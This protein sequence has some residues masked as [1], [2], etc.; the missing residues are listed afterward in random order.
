MRSILVV[1]SDAEQTDKVKA[2]LGAEGVWIAEVGD[3]TQALRVAADQ[4]PD[5]VVV[6]S[7]V[8]GSAELVRS[9]GSAVG[10][11]GSVLLR[12]KAGDAGAGEADSVLDLPL[13]SGR[14]AEEV[15]RLLAR[16]RAASASAPQEPGERR[17]TAEEIFG[18]ILREVEGTDPGWPPLLEPEPA[19]ALGASGAGGETAP[20]SAP[21]QAAESPAAAGE[22]AEQPPELERSA[23]PP[24]AATEPPSRPAAETPA[25]PAAPAAASHRFGHYEL[26]ER[27]AVGGMA[28]IW[29]ARMTSVEGFEK[30]V[31]IKKI[32]P[33]LSDSGDFER[34]FVE[35]A[36]L[37]AGLNHEN[38][39][40]IY[41]LGKVNEQYF[42]AMEYVEGRDLGAILAAARRR[43]ER[44]PTGLAV[45]VGARLAA[46]LDYAHRRPDAG[47]E[48]NAVVHRDVS[49][50]NVLVGR[51]G[52]IKLCD[53]GVAK[54]ASSVAS[55]Q[56]GAIKGKIPYMSPE[57]AHGRAVDGRSDLFSLGAVLFEMATGR[58]LFSADSEIS[59]L[60][61][62]RECRV[63]DPRELE[64]GLPDAFAEV[65]L[66]AL[67]R[68][69]DERFASASEMQHQLEQILYGLRPTPGAE[70]LARYLEA[71]FSPAE[72]AS[73]PAPA[74]RLAIQPLTPPPAVGP[75]EEREDE[76]AEETGGG[77]F[78]PAAASPGRNWLRLGL[79]ALLV[80][81][82]AAL[83]FFWLDGSGTEPEA[84]P[85]APVVA[86]PEPTPVDPAEPV[87][88][89]PET[90][91][92]PEDPAPAAGI[93][94]LVSRE[95]ARERAEREAELR[96]LF[97]EDEATLQQQLDEL[98]ESQ[99]GP[100]PEGGGGSGSGSPP[101]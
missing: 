35:E 29:T 25:V 59:L 36:K 50:R 5:L 30:R 96:R 44:V 71:V 18:D 17:L 32:L 54:M 24:E 2:A 39:I 45:L 97:Q 10:G 77:V 56:I 83:A 88:D 99:E 9:F 37:A 65:I 16:P 58:R 48:A 22:P 53:F 66:K 38:I 49:P 20:A 89:P 60:E 84:Q 63:R 92:S 21:R 76:T 61:A 19:P 23:A 86:S 11:P 26:G 70:D 75:P 52:R 33:H 64:P 4:A 7:R 12:R 42:I 46:A 47:G 57:Q 28:E 87:A 27:I 98:R 6:D 14:L 100:P 34:M 8:Q 51:D 94:E 78:L 1:S 79:L 101:G 91:A 81:A 15:S 68:D 69:P 3:R 72:A 93:E 55:T 67:R 62:V 85:P 90:E 82:L 43:G 13:D 80:A 40:H 31:A 74:P 95:L 73:E 41:D